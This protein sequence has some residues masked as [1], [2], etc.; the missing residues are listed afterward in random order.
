MERIFSNWIK[1][2]A[3][4]SFQLMLIIY[5]CIFRYLK[6][7]FIIPAILDVYYLGVVWNNV[8]TNR[9]FGGSVCAIFGLA[10]LVWILVFFIVFC[11]WK[12][13]KL[14]SKITKYLY[15]FL[16]VLTVFGIYLVI[17]TSCSNWT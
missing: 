5:L 12:I 14:Y 11:L 17:A 7:I 8:N 2:S 16:V 15:P 3:L 1:N 13:N 10:F 6:I 9:N 4:T